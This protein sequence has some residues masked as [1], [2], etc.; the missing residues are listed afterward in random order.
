MKIQHLTFQPL[1]ENLTLELTPGKLH[2]LHGKNGIGKTVLLQLVREKTGGALVNQRF[3]CMIADKFTF[4]QNL[5]FA[6][7]GRFPSPFA[8]MKK[9]KHASE[10]LTRFHIQPDTPAYKLSGGQRQILAVLMVLQR[11]PK[12]ILM[13]EPTAALDTENAEMVFS[14]LS[15]L[16]ETTLL[17]VC[18]DTSLITRFTTGSQFTL[19]LN[20][21]G[22]RVLNERPSHLSRM[23]PHTTN[24]CIQEG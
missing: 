22:L 19:S 12:L 14:F 20:E 7:M 16:S 2:A 15:T 24:L 5:Q 4:A 8:R 21:A 10:L 13:D 23:F 3:D 9:E 1:F 11:S 18:H 6:C 17:V